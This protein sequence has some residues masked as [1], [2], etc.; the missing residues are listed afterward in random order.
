MRET[1]GED[2]FLAITWYTNGSYAV[3]EGMQRFGWYGF[4]GTPSVMFD[5][6]ESVIGG[7]AGGSMFPTYNPIVLERQALA[8]PLIIDAIYFISS[9]EITL[10]AHIQ[11][12][13]TVTTAD[14]RVQFVI[15]EDGLHG[16]H[17]MGLRMLNYES[18][19]LTE[20]GESVV[21][22][23]TFALVPGWDEPN[24]AFFVFVQ[25]QTTKE[26]LQAARAVADYA[27]TVV[28]DG[29]P[30]GIAAPWQLTGPNGFD[31]SGEGDTTV[32]VFF[33]GPYT[34]TWLAVPGWELPPDNPQQQTVQE[35]GTVTFVG[36]YGG[37]PFTAVTTGPLG[38]DGNGRGVSLTDFDGDGD[39]DIYLVN[40]EGPN[41]LLRNDGDLA[42]SDIATGPVADDGPGTS[43]VFGD[44]DDDGD[45][46]LYIV[47]DGAANRLLDNEAGQFTE[48][49]PYGLDD[50]GAGRSAAWLDY[51]NDGRLDIYV[52]EHDG[53]NQLLRNIGQ[54]DE[55]FFFNPVS[56]VIADVGPGSAAPWSDFDS[57]GDLDVFIANRFG[58][59][60]MLENNL[61]MGFT[62]V[63][64][65]LLG[66][67]ANSTGAAWGDYDNDGDMDLYFTNDGQADR[68]LRQMSG[69]SFW[70]MVSDDLSDTGHGRGV[71]WADLD[72]DADLDLYVTR[73]NEADLFLRNDGDT[74]TRVP[75]GWAEA[76]GPSEAVACGD[77]DGDGAVDLYIARGDGQPSVLMHNEMA[78][79][80]H[81]LHL[82]L[83][84]GEGNRGAIGA[85]IQ[86]HA[87]G[88]TQTREVAGGGYL[89]QNAPVVAFGLGQ[90]A[91]VD[92]LSI[93]WP[94]GTTQVVVSGLGI[95]RTV[96]IIEGQEP[97][98]V[99]VGD[100]VQPSRFALGQAYPNPFNPMTTIAFSL[101]R[102][103]FA[104]LEVFAVDGRR[105]ATL[106]ADELSTGEH[107]TVWTGT[108]DLGLPV[109]S[110]TYFY[111]L[112]AGQEA[113]TGRMTLLR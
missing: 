29:E 76:A 5:G 75:L 107:R 56:G 106:L 77:L 111:R 50:D 71:L 67:P 28:I 65:G 25:S 39:I 63:T 3:P 41:R 43:A 74:F 44:Y 92:S 55:D 18:F 62:D 102:P 99:A 26:I 8:S 53:A 54:I 23:R 105:I 91:D 17:N 81:W 22:S 7:Q 21:V 57:D 45:A 46:D 12:D 36:T 2:Q 31:V 34:L 80:N 47:L 93:H 110:G 83:I 52:V 1:Y 49:F 58:P 109:P 40:H 69:G 10:T 27:A 88:I 42:F 13:Q 51:D 37:G 19:T 20:P 59:N 85:R 33:A 100:G 15:A 61:D 30:D 98:P 66:D 94:D 104:R 89:A 82:R 16:Q 78:A 112:S 90:T 38:D 84:G 6:T 70:L 79:G 60:V 113:A 64:I 9:D 35:D 4:S 32:P 103:G 87:G 95:D 108:N 68:L 101:T 73:H 97:I 72:N 14:N 86:L 96:A 24:M 11:V 48:V